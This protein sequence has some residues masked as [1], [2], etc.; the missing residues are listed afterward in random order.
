MK[1][2]MEYIEEIVENLLE[3]QRYVTEQRMKDFVEPLTIEEIDEIEQLEREIES[4]E[5]FIES[6]EEGYETLLRMEKEARRGIISGKVV[7]DK[8]EW[9][10]GGEETL[11]KKFIKRDLEDLGLKN[12]EISTIK[13]DI[14]EGMLDPEFRNYNADILYVDD[15]KRFITVL[16]G[17]DREGNKKALYYY[18]YPTYEEEAESVVRQIRSYNKNG[19]IESMT[20]AELKD[21]GEYTYYDSG[22]I[23]Y[24]YDKDGKKTVGLYEDDIVGGEYFEYDKDGEIKLSISQEAVTQCVKDGNRSYVIC[25][26]YFKPTGNGG[27]T[28]LPSKNMYDVNPS[29]IKRTAREMWQYNK[30]EK[31]S[32][33]EISPKRQEEVLSVLR[34][35]EPIF[36]YWSSYDSLDTEKR[37]KII[38]WFKGFSKGLKIN[39]KDNKLKDVIEESKEL[40]GKIGQAE[41]LLSEYEKQAPE[42]NKEG[43]TQADN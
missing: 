30:E 10:Y 20:R 6:T 4:D 12:I 36:E 23:V 41:E 38:S 33:I 21:T 37:E 9:L 27:Y 31:D 32:I 2:S 24:K 11:T 14:L 40:D 29:E 25:D 19:D 13:K 16:E 7:R 42:Q 26:G 34:I 43:Q 5:Q 3:K 8:E 22:S 15:K 17:K 18:P 28:C 35:M 39:P 1:Y